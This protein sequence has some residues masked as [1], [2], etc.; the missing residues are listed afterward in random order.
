MV[1]GMLEVSEKAFS[2]DPVSRTRFVHELGKLVHS[3]SNVR[4][5]ESQSPLRKSPTAFLSLSASYTSWLPESF[6][7]ESGGRSSLSLLTGRK[8]S[9]GR[10]RSNC[11]PL[12]Y[13]P[14]VLYL[15]E[16]LSWLLST[17]SG[18]KGTELYFQGGSPDSV[19]VTAQITLS[20]F[21]RLQADFL[22]SK[23]SYSRNW[24]VV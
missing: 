2:S 3:K 16:L 9:V 17:I 18:G 24:I 22:K 11:Y 12:S 4:A 8:S 15:G 19:R 14:S 6:L 13:Y 10:E 7:P 23:S 1:N 20:V 5:N 21:L